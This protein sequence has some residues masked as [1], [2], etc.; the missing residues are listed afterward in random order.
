MTFNNYKSVTLQMELKS[1][2]SIIILQNQVTQSGVGDISVGKLW[3][4]LQM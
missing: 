4:M 3:K 1:S 2:S